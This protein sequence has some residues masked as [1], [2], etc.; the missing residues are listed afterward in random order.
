MSEVYRLWEDGWD[1]GACG[2]KLIAFDRDMNRIRVGSLVDRCAACASDANATVARDFP[3][4]IGN[5]VIGSAIIR[6]WFRKAPEEMVEEV[7]AVKLRF[8][9]SKYSPEKIATWVENELAD[10]AETEL[11]EVEVQVTSVLTQDEMGTLK[12]DVCS[13]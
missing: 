10:A 2:H 7:F 8:D 13:G 4:E 11:S 9:K 12:I 3:L 1:R 6:A 5:A